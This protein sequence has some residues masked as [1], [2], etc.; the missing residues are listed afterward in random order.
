MLMVRWPIGPMT[1]WSD[2]PLVRKSIIGLKTIG[3]KKCVIDP[4]THWSEKVSLVRKAIG[5]K[6]RLIAE[7]LFT[8]GL[9]PSDGQD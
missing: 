5:L 2:E 1:H 6:I 7:F 3:P 8:S 9:Y 4:T